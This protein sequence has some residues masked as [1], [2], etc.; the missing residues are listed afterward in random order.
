MMILHFGDYLQVVAE[1][2]TMASAFEVI[3][4]YFVQNKLQIFGNVLFII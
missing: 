3:V 1:D 2:N 4:K